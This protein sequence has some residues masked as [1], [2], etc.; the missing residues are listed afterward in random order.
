MP[1]WYASALPNE[2]TKQKIDDH[3]RVTRDFSNS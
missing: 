3:E 2:M 1:N